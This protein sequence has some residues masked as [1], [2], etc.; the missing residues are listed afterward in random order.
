MSR[1]FL[2]IFS[3]AI[4][5]SLFASIAKNTDA[6]S[7]VAIPTIR[8]EV[9]IGASP[10]GIAVFDLSAYPRIIASD[11]SGTTLV[12]FVVEDWGTVYTS[13][14]CG[15]KTFT[16]GDGINCT[17]KSDDGGRPHFHMMRLVRSGYDKNTKIS[18]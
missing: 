13:S 16:I 2:P 1:A 7:T 10:D 18:E 11:L 3:L 9:N 15:S 14:G 12:H 6:Q 5:L 17:A 4:I 8:Q